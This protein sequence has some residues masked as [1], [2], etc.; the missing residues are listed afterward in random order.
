[1]ELNACSID[2]F[3]DKLTNKEN[4]EIMDLSSSKIRKNTSEIGSPVN[5][6]LL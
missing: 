2:N 6:V 3:N 4:N 1:M 5:K